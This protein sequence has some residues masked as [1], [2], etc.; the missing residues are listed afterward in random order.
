MDQPTRLLRRATVN[1]C[2]DI[3][4]LCATPRD[5]LQMAPQESFPLTPEV[6]AQ[7]LRERNSGYVLEDPSG[8]LLAYAELNPDRHTVGRFWIGH[9]A[10]VPGARNQ[11]IGHQMVQSLEA[12]ARSQLQATEIWIS[13][14]ADNPSA[15]A[16]YRGAGF[17]TE[18]TRMVM[19]RTLVDLSSRRGRLGPVF[20]TGAVATILF[21]A[22]IVWWWQQ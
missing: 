5:L 20:L 19:G 9:L 15:L 2:E 12:T 21:I 11:G 18:G 8:T 10:V 1:D 3:A 4:A 14:F 16:C 6:V 22:W 7:W 13:A 17:E